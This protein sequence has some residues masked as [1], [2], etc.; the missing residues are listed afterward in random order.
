MAKLCNNFPTFKFFSI[1]VL[2]RG[3]C[4]CFYLSSFSLLI[5]FTVQP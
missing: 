3:C 5:Q 2:G 4:F 1:S